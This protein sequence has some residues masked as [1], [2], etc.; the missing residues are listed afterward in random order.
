MYCRVLQ[1]VAVCCVCCGVFQCV[2]VLPVLQCA[3][4][5]CS[6]CC[7]EC[8]NGLQCLLQTPVTPRHT[9]DIISYWYRRLLSFFFVHA[10]EKHT[11]GQRV[12]STP[13]SS[14][15]RGKD[16]YWVQHWDAQLRWAAFPKEPCR[17]KG[18]ISGLWPTRVQFLHSW[19]MRPHGLSQKKRIYWKCLV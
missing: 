12:H 7:S 18:H 19:A 1:R 2:Q 10:P 14:K 13:Y 5:C 8:C 15:S 6:V 3:E 11:E 4:V 16:K 9:H 17:M